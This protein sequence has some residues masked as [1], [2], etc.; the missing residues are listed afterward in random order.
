MTKSIFGSVAGRVTAVTF[1][2][3]GVGGGMAVT[4][5]LPGFGRAPSYSVAAVGS[6]PGGP[7]IALDFPASVIAAPS[8]EAAAVSEVIEQ[9][10]VVAAPRK[11]SAP[12][13]AAPA[14]AAPQCVA[15]LTDAVNAITAAIP[16]VTTA[17]QGQALLAQANAVVAAGTECVNQA[18]RAG[19]PGADEVNRLVAQ[20]GGLVTQI[21]ALP[22]VS[23]L[24]PEQ[25]AQTPNL[26]GGV[27]EG[28]GQVV[29]GT[30][31]MVNRGLGLLGTG[32]NL[33]TAPVK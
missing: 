10:V 6:A 22:V 17:E 16:T 9:V 29:G 4:G 14:P 11:V 12:A 5:A 21:Q 24:T 25:L 2:L 19:F 30:L 32:L 13:P 3:S 31:N 1:L 7:G 15:D 23:A 28:V 18:T 20:A 8:V 27:V 26:V 33:L